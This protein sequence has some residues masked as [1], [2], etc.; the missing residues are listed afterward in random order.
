MSRGP[1]SEEP[2]YV[3][4]PIPPM[5]EIDA[6]R[7]RAIGVQV[8]AAVES[9]LTKGAQISGKQ[10]EKW[11]PDGVGYFFRVL[12]K[13]LA[14]EMAKSGSQTNTGSSSDQDA[15][16]PDQVEIVC[17]P[18]ADELNREKVVSTDK[19]WTDR[20]EDP[21][22]VW[23]RAIIH[24]LIVAA[25]LFALAAVLIELQATLVPRVLEQIRNWR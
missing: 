8:R 14:D 13:R 6:A 24:G 10:F 25:A 22:S 15:N 23:T 5:G 18:R 19:G 1:D 4:A 21:R 9:V 3:P 11:G 2:A 12:R 17:T 20:Q 16:A 7:R